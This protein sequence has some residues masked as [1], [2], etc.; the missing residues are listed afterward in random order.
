MGETDSLLTQG[1]L[2]GYDV[3]TKDGF[4]RTVHYTT[5]RF[6]RT[7]LRILYGVPELP[8]IHNSMRLALL[9]MKDVHQGHDAINRRKSPSDIIGRSRQ[10]AVIFKPYNLALQVVRDCPQCSLD[11]AKK[12]SINQKMGQV[13]LNCITL[14]PPFSNVS[15]DLA[16]LF[17]I[18]YKERKTW[19]LIYLCNVSKA[20][21]LQPVENYSAKAVTTAL[22]SLESK[23][24]LTL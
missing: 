24:F 22:N 16:G 7:S 5:G 10:Y 3:Q 2:Q 12:K 4:T 11:D 8:I 15:A 23:I 14:S 18:K 1:R 6:R 21:H 19:V 17:R 20:L 9:I 13:G